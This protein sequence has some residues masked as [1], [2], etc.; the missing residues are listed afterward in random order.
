VGLDPT[1]PVFERAKTVHAS[2]IS[3]EF[4][5][6]LFSTRKE[7]ILQTWANILAQSLANINGI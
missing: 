2:V 1:I 6:G 5:R 4:L 7:N 3:Y